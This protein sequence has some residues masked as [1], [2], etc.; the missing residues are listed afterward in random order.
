M[1]ACLLGKLSGREQVREH[2]TMLSSGTFHPIEGVLALVECA[3]EAPAVK[4]PVQAIHAALVVLKGFLHA[5]SVT[6]LAALPG[7]VEVLLVFL[8]SIF[9]ILESHIFRILSIAL[10]KQSGRRRNRDGDGKYQASQTPMK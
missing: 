3:L 1:R 2:F 4:R 7:L 5:R 9:H 6:R 10:C 8:E